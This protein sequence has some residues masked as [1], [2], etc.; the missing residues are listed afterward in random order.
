MRRHA[1]G[2]IGIV[3]LIGAA[4]GLAQSGIN[5][6]QNSM[7]ASILLRVGL[8]LGAIWLAYP[9]LEQ[10]FQRVPPWLVAVVGLALLVVVVRPKA[11]FAVAPILGAVAVLQFFGWLMRP[12]PQPKRKPSQ[13]RKSDDEA[14]L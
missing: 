11:I 4:I 1:F 8:V 2:L 10:L 7:L 6:A 14:R 5:D 12:L 3:F 9:Q 13:R